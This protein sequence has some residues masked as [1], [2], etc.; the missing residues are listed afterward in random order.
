LT[1]IVNASVAGN[2]SYTNL[3]ARGANAQIQV[4]NGQLRFETQNNGAAIGSTVGY[5]PSAMRWWRIKTIATPTPAIRAEYSSNG[6]NWTQLGTDYAVNPPSMIGIEITAGTI[7]IGDVG[8][9][10]FDQVMICP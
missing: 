7:V 4:E 9:T 10:V 5:S 8:T 3:L 2:G 6:L 1:A